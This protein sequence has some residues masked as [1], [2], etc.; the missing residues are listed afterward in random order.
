MNQATTKVMEVIMEGAS[1]ERKDI[2]V[3]QFIGLSLMNQ[4]TT[5]VM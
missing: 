5:K 2:V 1:S 4:A 3:A